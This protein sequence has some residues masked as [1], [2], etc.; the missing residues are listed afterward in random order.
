MI[1][2][3]QEKNNFAIITEHCCDVEAAEF[4]ANLKKLDFIENYEVSV[5]CNI[6]YFV[7]NNHSF[8]IIEVFPVSSAPTRQLI[9]N[10]GISLKGRYLSQNLLKS[11]HTKTR[12]HVFHHGVNSIVVTKSKFIHILSGRSSSR[13]T[14]GYCQMCFLTFR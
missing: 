13:W 11:E 12:K 14:F 4:E 3:A 1:F 2:D 6:L 9:G 5:N 10:I 7:F 8:Y